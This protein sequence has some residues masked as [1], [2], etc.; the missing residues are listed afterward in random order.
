[1]TGAVVSERIESR[2]EMPQLAVG[3]DQVVDA[4]GKGARRMRRLTGAGATGR[5][6][7]RGPGVEPGEE[8]LPLCIQRARV[9][10]VLSVELVDVLRVG[11]IDDVERKRRLGGLHVVNLSKTGSLPKVARKRSPVPANDSRAP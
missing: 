9:A 10:L 11:A 3:V 2:H 1:M 7:P 6:V 5:L 4:R 8:R